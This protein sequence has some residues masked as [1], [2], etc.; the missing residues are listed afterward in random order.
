L[1]DSLA[2]AFHEASGQYLGYFL[3]LQIQ[4]PERLL[5]LAI[6]VKEYEQLEQMALVKL[7]VEHLN[8]NIIVFDP[9]LEI[10]IKW[11]NDGKEN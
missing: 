4:E 2:S 10:T 1:Q 9:E 3:G 8:M 7:V 11:L 5:F 6:P